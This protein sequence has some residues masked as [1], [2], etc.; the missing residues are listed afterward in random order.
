MEKLKRSNL[1]VEGQAERLRMLI[2][3]SGL[4][5]KD[6]SQLIGKTTRTVN[7]WE[8][9]KIP[10]SGRNMASIAAAFERIGFKCSEEWL[11]NGSGCPPSMDG[12]S[13]ELTEKDNIFEHFNLD[14]SIS[15]IILFY[16]KIYPDMLSFVVRDNSYF[17]RLRPSTLLIGVSVP[18]DKLRDDWEFGYLYSETNLNTIP[19][20][21]IKKDNELWLKPFEIKGYTSQPVKVSENQRLYPVINVRPIY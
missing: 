19:A 8:N 4:Q 13:L 7:M 9:G 1:E 2:R 21:L 16:K 3:L 15:S 10:I 5:K 6:F 14:F 20:D 11:K 17:P 12:F 18:Q